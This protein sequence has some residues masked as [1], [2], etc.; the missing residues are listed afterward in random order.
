MAARIP[1]HL[2]NSGNTPCFRYFTDKRGLGDVCPKKT[3]ITN[4]LRLSAQRAPLFL[5][6]C[7]Q[8]QPDAPLE[9]RSRQ[10]IVNENP[11]QQDGKP[12]AE[13]GKQTPVAFLGDAA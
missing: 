8:C 1:L 9:R 6:Y 13:N 2:K 7:Q 11:D 4:P 5:L 10:G 12:S 3:R